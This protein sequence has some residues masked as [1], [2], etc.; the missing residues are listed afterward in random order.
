ML[1]KMILLTVAIFIICTSTTAF[2][3]TTSDSAINKEITVNV[4]GSKVNFTDAKPYLSDTGRAMVPIRALSEALQAKVDWNGICIVTKGDL[5]LVIA[6]DFGVDYLYLK[7]KKLNKSKSFLMDSPPTIK[8]GRTFVPLRVINEAFGYKVS[9]NK[10]TYTVEIDTKN[11]TPVVFEDNPS[12]PALFEGPYVTLSESGDVE[13]DL[14]YGRKVDSGHSYGDFDK[15]N[16][17][18]TV[19]YTK[20]SVEESVYGTTYGQYHEAKSLHYPYMKEF[21]IQSEVY[22]YALKNKIIKE[23][24]LIHSNT[25]VMDKEA[26]IPTEVMEV[27]KLKF[28]YHGITNENYLKKYNG[29]VKIDTW[30]ETPVYIILYRDALGDYK[31]HEIVLGDTWTEVK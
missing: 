31:L 29:L 15:I 2:A 14:K 10:E 17:Y 4:D 22:Q 5:E 30:Y 19:D 6:V 25:I 21:E 24:K 20:I 23:V 8:S 12:N 13:S 3:E 16:K 9:W 7:N 1:R 11:S 26:G 18:G 27:G 28:I